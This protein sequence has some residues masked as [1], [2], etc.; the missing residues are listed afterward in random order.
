M[1]NIRR[2]EFVGLLSWVQVIESNNFTHF[3]DLRRTFG[4]ADCVR[5]HTRPHTAFNISGNKY[6]LIA[7]VDYVLQA[8]LV[9]HV[10]THDEYE[11]GLWRQ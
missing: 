5:P 8:V 9:E 11:E 7:V 3:V 10:L 4:S 6:R 2:C 1:S